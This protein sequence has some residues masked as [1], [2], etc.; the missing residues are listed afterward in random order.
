MI[1]VD[2]QLEVTKLFIRQKNTA[3]AASR[4]ILLAGDR[5]LLHKPPTAGAVTNTLRIFVPAL[6]RFTVEQTTKPVLVL[7]R[8][9]RH[10][11]IWQRGGTDD[12]GGLFQKNTAGPWGRIDSH[13]PSLSL[14][15]LLT[16]FLISP[17]GLNAPINTD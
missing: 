17:I 1:H 9:T 15:S 2:E 12:Q 5:A 11:K 16:S 10:P 7:R 3:I 14:V 13:L 4:R 8:R 6:Q